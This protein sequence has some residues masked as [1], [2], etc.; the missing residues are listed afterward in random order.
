[1]LGKL[2]L[3]YSQ[4]RVMLVLGEHDGQTVGALGAC[5]YLDSGTLSPLLKRM[6]VA[7]F[8]APPARSCGRSA[9][10]GRPHRAGAR[11]A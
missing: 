3:N 9:R 7:G 1:V 8:V 11:T 10:D 5:L 6:E 2:D 4:Y